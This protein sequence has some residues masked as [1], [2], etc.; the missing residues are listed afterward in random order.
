MQKILITGSAG[1]IGRALAP[2]LSEAGY[3]PIP[4]DIQFPEST[5][6][7]GDITQIETLRRAIPGCVGVINLAAVSRVLWGEQDPDKCHAT[8]FHGVRNILQVA[9]EQPSSPWV[10]FSSSR[11]VYGEPETLPVV[12][13]A[14][15][16]PLNVYAR[17]KYLAEQELLAARQRG[18][19][20]AIV[21]LSNVYG[22]IH[23][24]ADRVIP[25]FALA[26]A[27]GTSMRVDGW[28]HTFD[29]TH[30]DDTARGILSMVERLQEGA[31]DLP[32]IHLLTGK[33]TTL[34]ELATFAN[35]LGKR[36]STITQAPERDFD[37][38]RFYGNPARAKFLLGWQAEISIEDG[39]K[40]LITDF[41][42][43]FND[44]TQEAAIQ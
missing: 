12:E 27:Q 4:F 20:T 28:S 22:C 36:T 1:L 21:R 17:A 33:P 40:R 23:D 41:V 34:G 44:G 6:E 37:V 15:L 29:F 24:H 43:E 3:Q 11:E 5:P 8:N 2:L 30:V 16:R 25:A 13:D 7:Y 10:L 14:P 39:L 9:S 26:A 32:P 42:T 38:A 18:I 31:Q 35:R 19:Q